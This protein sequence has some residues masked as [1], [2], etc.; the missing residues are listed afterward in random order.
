MLTCGLSVAA[1]VLVGAGKKSN[2]NCRKPRKARFHVGVQILLLFFISSHIQLLSYSSREAQQQL[3]TCSH[4][5]HGET[6]KAPLTLVNTKSC[7]NRRSSSV[8]LWSSTSDHLI[9]GKIL[10][11]EPEPCTTK[12]DFGVKKEKK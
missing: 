8:S 12:S 2:S 3:R 9:R 4:S 1:L 11:R 5:L 7:F 10:K 6:E